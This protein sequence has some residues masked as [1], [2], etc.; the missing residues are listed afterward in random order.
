MANRSSRPPGSAAVCPLTQRSGRCFTSTSALSSPEALR[1]SLRNRKDSLQPRLQEE[2]GI[3]EES[4]D[5]PAM[6]VYDPA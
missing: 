4:F 6:T 1:K 5:V 2:L 3:D